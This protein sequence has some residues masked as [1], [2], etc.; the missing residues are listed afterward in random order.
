MNETVDNVTPAHSAPLPLSHRVSAPAEL[1]PPETRRGVRWRPLQRADLGS[2]LT[3]L[4]AVNPIDNPTRATSLEELTEE[5]DDPMFDPDRDG[6]VALD[7]S[8]SLI[9]YG[10]V[11]PNEVNETIVWI[12]LDGAVHPGHRR[13]GI[14]TALL[15][16]LER[17]G[18]Q[19]LAARHEP[20]PGWL[21]IDVSEH[22]ESTAALLDSHGFHGVRWFFDMERD[23]T[24]PI[25]HAPLPAGTQFV[26]YTNELS[27]DAR[28]TSNEAFR[29]HWGSQPRSTDDWLVGELRSDFRASLT[30]LVSATEGPAEASHIVG[31][32]STDVPEHEWHAR[33]RK[34]GYI[35]EIAVRRAWRGRGI[36]RAL[37]VHAMHAYRDLGLE[38]AVLSVDSENSSGAVGL[39]TDLGFVLRERSTTFIKEF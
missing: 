37:V 15:E 6:I 17:R 16:W 10:M 9:A 21:A 39:Y 32:L 24:A 11:T 25:P 27:E 1:A 20:L 28:T 23:L 36:A 19:H 38:L 8:G 3:L 14:G 4:N 2:V 18:R 30:T 7:A 13:Q 34:F 29:D 12:Y 22:A 35:N 31:L 26:S 33:G 5:F